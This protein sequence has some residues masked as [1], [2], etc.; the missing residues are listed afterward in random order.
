MRFCVLSVF[1]CS[2]PTFVFRAFVIQPVLRSARQTRKI[3]VSE[4]I[5]HRFPLRQVV[6]AY[7]V[8]ADGAQSRALKIIIQ[9]AAA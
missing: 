6:D 5:T 2:K 1:S 8:F 3:N 7:A 4:I 9:S